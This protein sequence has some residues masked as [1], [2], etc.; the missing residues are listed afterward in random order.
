MQG[1]TACTLG[2][3]GP[4]LADELISRALESL[5]AARRAV[6]ILGSVGGGM[7]SKEAARAAAGLR[8]VASSLED[9]ADALEL[10]AEYARLREERS[11]ERPP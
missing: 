6:E 11:R 7:S 2:R 3:E 8:R 5:P 4:I 1:S 9:A 10:W